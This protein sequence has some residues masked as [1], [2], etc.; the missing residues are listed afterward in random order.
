M[1]ITLYP[2]NWLYNAGVIGLLRVLEQA[3]EN[4]QS[5]LRDDGSV[6]VDS[7][8]FNEERF[9][10]VKIPK[11]IKSLI[12]HLVPDSD[13]NDWKEDKN[14]KKNKE[15]YEDFFKKF[16]NNDFGYKF[17]RAGNKLFSSNTPF[18]NLVQP[19]EWRSFKFTEL[20]LKI[21]QIAN[22]ASHNCT[23]IRCN[24]CSENE[25]NPKSENGINPKS[26]LEQRLATLQITHLQELGGS[27]G[28]FPNSFW[29]L[30]QSSPICILCVYLILHYRESFL[31]L[32]DNSEIFINAPSF[33]TMWYLNKYA[34]DVVGRTGMKETKK[35]LG[36][37]L[38]ELAARLEAQLGTW[39]S[40]NLEVITKDGDNIDFFSLP[41]HIILLL[42][43]KE[44]ASL[45]NQIGEF[46]IL[47]MVLDGNFREILEL[48]ERI[49]KIALKPQKE[50]NK[51][52]RDFVNS[53][54]KLERN[55]NKLSNFSSNL[56]ELY[57]LL[58][59]KTSKGVLI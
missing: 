20:L 10:E 17:I 37:S 48:G 33:K 29:N 39:T 26:D 28:K 3:G 41:Y 35:I 40:M 23:Q 45:L 42:T 57:A 31:K 2:S 30:E 38:I 58:D 27:L 15:K 53:T 24:L 7:G 18:Q 1:E 43:G 52:E 32:L 12:E 36:I 46:K 22:R 34:R 44:V 51:S 4:V 16:D 13:L 55:K 21:P 50:R 6:E 19:T 8:I 47:N 9:G 11:C 25:I 5:Y 49:L 56:L 54:V 14:G 59:D